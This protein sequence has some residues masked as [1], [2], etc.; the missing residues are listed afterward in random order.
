MLCESCQCRW[1]SS[2]RRSHP[3]RVYTASLYFNPL[4]SAGLGVWKATR[5]LCV[6]KRICGTQVWL[7][8]NI[9][10]SKSTM[11]DKLA[12]GLPHKGSARS[13]NEMWLACRKLWW[14]TLRVV[15]ANKMRSYGKGIY[16]HLNVNILTHIHYMTSNFF[17]T[18]TKKYC[19]HVFF[20]L[21]IIHI[22]RHRSIMQI[23]T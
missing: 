23:E 5:N 9:V 17:A 4:V 22:I 3:A 21:S 6:V 19:I 14:L 18:S 16:I 12:V 1:A 13:H 20:F 11:C 15:Y 10:A 7:L 8:P 2:W